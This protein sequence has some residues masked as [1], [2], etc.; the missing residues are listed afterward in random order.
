[1]HTFIFKQAYLATSDHVGFSKLAFLP[2]PSHDL[3][4]FVAMP[5][6]AFTNDIT[7]LLLPDSK[8]QSRD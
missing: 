4:S 6:F 3:A 8:H 5:P 2:H 1:M 7:Y